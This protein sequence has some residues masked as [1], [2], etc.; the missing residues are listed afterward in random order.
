MTAVRFW[1]VVA[2]LNV[3]FIA[4]DV[5]RIAAWPLIG[6]PW[7]TAAAAVFS[8][9]INGA[10]FHWVALPALRDAAGLTDL[11]RHDWETTR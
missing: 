10:T 8:A 1:R 3:L 2:V 6:L 4:N 7:P 9:A 11:I 5:L